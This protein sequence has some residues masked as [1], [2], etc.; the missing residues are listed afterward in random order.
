MKI[1]KKQNINLRA[2]PQVTCSRE[3]VCPRD[4]RPV[5]LRKPLGEGTVEP[6]PSVRAETRAPTA[7]GSSGGSAQIQPV[8]LRK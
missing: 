5:C 3:A 4:R 7:L 1:L 8:T 6:G 2:G